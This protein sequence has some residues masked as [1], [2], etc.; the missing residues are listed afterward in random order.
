[1]IHK[2]SNKHGGQKHKKCIQITEN[3]RNAKEDRQEIF[4]VKALNDNIQCCKTL[5]TRCSHAL[6]AVT[7]SVR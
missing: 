2:T 4:E 7:Y 1:M 3:Q 5:R 6:L